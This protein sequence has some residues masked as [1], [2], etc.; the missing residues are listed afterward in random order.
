MKE[1]QVENVL[2]VVVDRKT[3]H[4]GK[5]AEG[6]ALRNDLDG[7]MCC[8][9]FVSIVCGYTAQQIT[10]ISTPPRLYRQCRSA[11]SSKILP[12]F[13]NLLAFSPLTAST[14]CIIMM[15]VNDDR[16]I[17]EAKRESELSRVAATINVNLTFVD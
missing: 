2:D 16:N 14:A 15:E 11:G 17:S 9:G 10:N 7:N 5:G 13:N 3:W 1:T 6:S 12:Q 4:R 8:L